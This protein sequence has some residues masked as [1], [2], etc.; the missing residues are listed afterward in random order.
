MVRGFAVCVSAGL[1]LVL[2]LGGAAHANG[3]TGTAATNT[4]A[5]AGTATP[6]SGPALRSVTL[7]T[8]ERVNVGV[9]GGNTVYIPSEDS[10]FLSYQG[11]NS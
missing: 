2:A 4:A 9:V 1:G 8:G 10:G 7:P 5:V 3:T 6:L 11:T